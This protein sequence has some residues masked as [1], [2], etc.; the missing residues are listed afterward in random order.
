MNRITHLLNLPGVV[1]CTCNLATLEVEFRNDVGSIPVGGSSPS[2]G[3]WI[4]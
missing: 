3:R 1:A 2:L 4:V